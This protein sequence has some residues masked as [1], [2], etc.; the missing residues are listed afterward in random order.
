MKIKDIG[1]NK[2]LLYVNL[3]NGFQ[4]SQFRTFQITIREKNNLINNIV[5]ENIC[6]LTS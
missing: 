3:I 1:I 6:V 2:N 4:H 5:N